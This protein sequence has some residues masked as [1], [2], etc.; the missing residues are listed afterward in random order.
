MLQNNL[1]LIVQYPL[2]HSSDYVCR[3]F[4]GL[5][6]HA[7]VFVTFE[8]ATANDQELANLLGATFCHEVMRLSGTT[9]EHQMPCN[10]QQT[11][12]SCHAISEPTCKKILVQPAG[13]QATSNN[14]PTAPNV[15][16]HWQQN[17]KSPLYSV[18]QVVPSSYPASALRFPTINACLWK[19][20]PIESVWAILQ[21]AGI[22]HK[23]NQI[24][25][26]YV[27]KDSAAIADQLFQALTNEGFDIFL[28][29]CSV[30]IGVQFQ[31]HLMQDICDKAMVVLLNTEGVKNSHWVGEE[32]A[33]V[34]TYRLGLLEI[35]FPNVL[36]RKDIDSDFTEAITPSDLLS[37]GSGYPA[38]HPLLTT[39]KLTDIVERIKIEH[40]RAL[41]R[42]RIE[43]INNLAVALTNAR[44]SS[45]ILPDGTILVRPSKYGTEKVIAL[46]S[47]TPT[48]G[49]F[50]L[51]HQHG[52]ISPTREGVIVSPAP[53]FQAHRLNQISWL[54][55]ISNI[56]HI[57]EA[58]LNALAASI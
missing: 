20:H 35:L 11:A 22:G 49:D 31:E 24:F 43:L 6:L 32:I 36:K 25:I 55:E 19:K 16:R 39:G 42:R 12:I 26:S 7:P 28:D 3:G 29:R 23:E 45:Q 27:R 9:E 14:W 15:E 2:R 17:I 44:K 53:L 52:K 46:T 1:E 38:G 51:L 57:N 5:H 4:K 48:L 56:Q 37:A 33:I 10:G 47:R 54:G 41:H 18:V 30:P 58:Q 13:H 40:G 50:S 8:G 21:Q 34:K